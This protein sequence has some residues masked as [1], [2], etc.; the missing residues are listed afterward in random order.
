MD[1]P[2]IKCP[3]V[4]S[5]STIVIPK[6]GWFAVHVSAVEPNAKLPLANLDQGWKNLLQEQAVKNQLTF[7]S[8]LTK[9][10]TRGRELF[11]RML[12]HKIGTSKSESGC[13]L[14]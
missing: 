8:L 14:S 1:T 4:C 10:E 6:A 3:C 11:T 5:A 7:M 9:L 2:S 12:A 13:H